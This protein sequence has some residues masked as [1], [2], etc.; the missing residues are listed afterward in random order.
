MKKILNLLMVFS[1]LFLL[2]A[3]NNDPDDPE[4]PIIPTDPTDTYWDSDGNGVPDWQEEEITLSYATWQYTQ[5]DMVTIDV[6]MIEAFEEMYPNINVEMQVVGE[7]YDWDTLFLGL[8]EANT[9][10]DVFLV[11]RLGSFLPFNILADITEMY[12]NDPDTEYIFDSVSGLGT[13]NDKRY[14]IPTFIY[15]NLWFVN[16]DMLDQA[17]INK[18]SYDWTYEQM[19]NIAKSTTNLTNHEFGI[20][21]CSFYTRVYPK[22]L[23]IQEN[24]AVGKDWYAYSYD[25]NR[26][27][28]DDPVMQT[29]ANKMNDAIQQGYCKPGFSAEELEEWYADSTFQPTY[30]GKVAMWAEASWSAKDYFES[31]T[32]D[33]D[34]YPGPNGVTGGN[35]D[36]GGISSLSEHKQAAYQLLKWMSYGEE[37]LLKRFE[38]YEDVGQELFQ[39]GNNFPYPI[40]DYGIDGQGVNQVWTHIP[41]GSV[42][43][44]FVSPQ[45]IESLRNGAFWANKEVIGWDAVDSAT[46]PYFTEIMDGTNTYAALKDMIQAA[47]DQAL[48]ESRQSLDDMLE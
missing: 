10:P 24:P 4:D 34:A 15:P 3:C 20:A 45:F 47:A 30:G 25:G 19:E 46:G 18:P 27:N 41:Y 13:Y 28:F 22:V 33:W 7:W 32:F 48:A 12:E 16:L 14:A 23:K 36:I 42:A 6:L 31:F 38:I 40:V 44:G 5:P 37:G 9:L 39:Q 1:A 26:F 8:L 21:G 2:V 35:T 29:G 11:Q 17:G 43:P